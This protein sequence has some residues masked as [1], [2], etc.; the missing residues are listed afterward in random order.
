MIKKK[1]ILT[2][3][4]IASAPRPEIVINM[5]EEV[6]SGRGPGKLADE[7]RVKTGAALLPGANCYINDG[8]PSWFSDSCKLATRVFARAHTHPHVHMRTEGMCAS[9]GKEARNGIRLGK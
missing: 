3:L 5:F 6:L 1:K 7:Q 9:E 2:G 4:E 8:F